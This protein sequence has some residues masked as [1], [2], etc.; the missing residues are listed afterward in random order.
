MPKFD[1]ANP[2]TYCRGEWTKRGAL[3]KEMFD[4]CV[5]EQTEGYANAVAALKKYGSYD[6]MPTLFKAVWA[7]WTKRG[8]TQY[9]MIAYGLNQQGEAFLDHEYERKQPNF[10]AKKMAGCEAQWRDNAE[11]RWT[12]TMYCY[13]ND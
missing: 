9:T 7:Q 4:Y 13:K 6:W 2:D 10:D 5:N 3:D 11:D 1:P 12:M 8:V